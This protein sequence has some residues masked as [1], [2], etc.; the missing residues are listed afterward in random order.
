MPRKTS[1]INVLM[2]SLG[3]FSKKL[4]SKE[5]A[6]FL[7]QLEDYRDNKIP[8]SALLIVLKAWSI[9]YNEEY[10]LQQ[11]FFEPYPK[12]LM[13]LTDSGKGRQL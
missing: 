8:I 10:L 3:F 12:D 6:F 13:S 9:K 11:T 7:E 2:H 4:G 1:N 5:K